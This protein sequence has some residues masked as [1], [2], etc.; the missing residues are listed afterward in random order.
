MGAYSSW[1]AMALTHHA[2][3]RYAALRAGTSSKGRYVILGDDIVIADSAIAKEYV[4][5]MAELDVTISEA[6]THTSQNLYEF[7][8]RWVYKNQEITA[9]PVT[10]IPET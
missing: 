8:K 6:K 10:A 7:A 5:V 4:T 1:P 9:F 2:L 3:V